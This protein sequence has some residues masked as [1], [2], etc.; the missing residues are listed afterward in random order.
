MEWQQLI[1]DAFK[2]V[3]YLRDLLKGKGWSGA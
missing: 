2:Q 3:A 1:I